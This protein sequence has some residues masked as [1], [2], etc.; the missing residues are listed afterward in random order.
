MFSAFGAL[1]LVIAAVGLYSVVAYDVAQRAH[2]LSVRI[3]LGARARD[4]I[5]VVVSQGVRFALVGIAFGLG[6][7]LLGAERLQPLLFR[8][9]A[10]DPSVYAAVGMILLLAAIGACVAPA[11]R[12]ARADP[13]LALRSD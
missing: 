6:I 9:S 7:A 5:R 3:A 11:R 1:A 8:Q 4:V 12:A 2:E 10:S 13:N